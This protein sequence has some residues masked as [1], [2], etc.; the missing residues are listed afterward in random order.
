MPE[1]DHRFNRVVANN[2]HDAEKQLENEDKVDQFKWDVIEDEEI[3]G[4]VF[5][6]SDEELDECV[7]A[8]SKHLLS[9]LSVDHFSEMDT[10]G[11]R[12]VIP[13]DLDLHSLLKKRFEEK[14]NVDS[15]IDMFDFIRVGLSFE[16]SKNKKPIYAGEPPQ[17]TEKRIELDA[18]IQ[19]ALPPTH[20][21]KFI[22]GLVSLEDDAM[23]VND[24]SNMVSIEIPVSFEAIS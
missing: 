4:E 7:L 11:M 8:L 1:E 12:F 24:E 20:R 3:E 14:W 10:S 6:A 16:F 23:V 21:K 13:V 22:S 5:N 15:R 18:K 19:A 2:E 17:P 9:T